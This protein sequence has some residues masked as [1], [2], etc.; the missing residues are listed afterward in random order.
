MI[1]SNELVLPQWKVTVQQTEQQNIFRIECELLLSLT[2]FY[3]QLLLKRV[4]VHEHRGAAMP[5]D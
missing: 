4:D 3:L 2:P 1:Y 5:P